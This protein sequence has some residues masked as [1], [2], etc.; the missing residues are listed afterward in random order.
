MNGW[1]GCQRHKENRHTGQRRLRFQRITQASWTTQC[2]ARYV[3]KHHK[4]ISGHLSD[5]KECSGQRAASFHV[6]SGM[7][8]VVQRLPTTKHRACGQVT[9]RQAGAKPLGPEHALVLEH[10]VAGSAEKER[11]QSR[12]LAM[13]NLVNKPLPCPAT[14]QAVRGP[15]HGVWPAQLSAASSASEVP[16]GRKRDFCFVSKASTQEAMPEFIWISRR[17][18]QASFLLLFF[19]FHILLSGFKKVL[20]IS[21][22]INVPISAQLFNDI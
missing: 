22:N 12:T 10:S 6:C 8:R 14:T 20:V 9:L 3:P 1:A 5:R 4:I 18:P 21:K 17:H 2:Q 7:N 15:A 16:S 11:D 13:C 19:F